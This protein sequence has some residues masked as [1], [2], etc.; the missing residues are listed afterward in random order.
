MKFTRVLHTATNNNETAIH[1]LSEDDKRYEVLLT[2]EV[3]PQ[4]MAALV[5]AATILQRTDP[6]F[7]HGPIYTV[8]GCQPIL[9]E[10]QQRGLALTTKE[11]FDISMTIDAAMLDALQAC[12]AEIQAGIH[13]DGP[14]H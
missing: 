14:V 12:I 11:G 3:V 13:H 7:H 1:L 2:S 4:V 9:T 10:K 5:R 6:T 8:I